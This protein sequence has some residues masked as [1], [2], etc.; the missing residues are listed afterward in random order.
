MALLED[1]PALKNKC[2]TSERMRS[3]QKGNTVDL[4]HVSHAQT[5][6]Y[7]AVPR[8]Q[9]KSDLPAPRTLKRWNRIAKTA[10]G[11]ALY[12]LDRLFGISFCQGEL[13]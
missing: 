5:V 2:R 8:G 6:A 12:G 13:M 9:W 4:K 3:F 1:S 11:L 7:L 10:F